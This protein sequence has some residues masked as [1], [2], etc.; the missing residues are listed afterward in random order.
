MFDVG[1]CIHSCRDDSCFGALKA[2][3]WGC[4]GAMTARTFVCVYICNIV[5]LQ[6]CYSVCVG[7]C[8]FFERGRE[9]D[10]FYCM[11]PCLFYVLSTHAS[12]TSC[13]NETLARWRWVS[14]HSTWCE[15]QPMRGNSK[16]VSLGWTTFHV[17]DHMTSCDI[18]DGSTR[19]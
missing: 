2:R 9:R 5:Y 14:V 19:T 17:W 18:M 16:N 4:F 13:W 3:V 6:L 15:S 10:L 11:F 8:R 12:S 7:L 1:M